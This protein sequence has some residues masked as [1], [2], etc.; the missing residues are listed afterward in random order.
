MVF[1]Q[2][3]DTLSTKSEGN[4]DQMWVKLQPKAENSNAVTLLK[5]FNLSYFGRKPKCCLLNLQRINLGHYT[6]KTSLAVAI[7]KTRQDYTRF[8]RGNWA[9]LQLG[10]II[11]RLLTQDHVMTRTLNTNIL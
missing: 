9:V 7:R 8:Y 11:V 6:Y 3:E 2:E 5:E 1:G 10:A 4:Q